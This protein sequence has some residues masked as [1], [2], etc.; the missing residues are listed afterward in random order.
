MSSGLPFPSEAFVDDKR[1]FC[2]RCLKLACDKKEIP[3]MA[4]DEAVVALLDEHE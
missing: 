1:I 4:L 2:A 3:R